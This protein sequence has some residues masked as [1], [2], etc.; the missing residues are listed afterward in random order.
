MKSLLIVFILLLPVAA[1][2]QNSNQRQKDSLRTAIAKSAGKE[3]LDS[4]LKLALLYFPE[5]ADDKKMD[6]L[7]TLY[8]QINDEA[9]RQG[10]IK[11]QEAALGNTL[12]ALFNK[13]N[14]DEIIRLAPEYMEKTDK[15]EA[16]RFHYVIFN[17]YFKAYLAKGDD[18]TALAEAKQ[19]YDRAQKN[20]D[21]YGMATALFCMSDLYGRQERCD[22][23]E[24]YLRQSIELW[25][26]LGDKN[27][28]KL[29]EACFQLCMSLCGQQKYDD[30]L[31]AA[32]EFE[33]VVIRYEEYL[34]AEQLTARH[35]LYTVYMIIYRF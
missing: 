7:L 5:T 32:A 11:S 14:Y 18:N 31:Q 33:K 8:R 15:P 9:V 22:E 28:G 26:T 25:K 20:S 19:M 30:A 29:T 23:Q 4:Q 27:L 6:T 10:D 2:A 21:K 12:I 13:G 16:E 17:T 24:K 1:A 34:K 35:N 3:K